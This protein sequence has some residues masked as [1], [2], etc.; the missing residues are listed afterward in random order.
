MQSLNIPTARVKQLNG[1]DDDVLV[2][3]YESAAAFFYSSLYE[4]FGAPV[5]EAM[6]LGF[7]VACANTGSIPEVAGEAAESFNPSDS[8]DICAAIT[9]IVA[10][11][12]HRS[13]LMR[14]GPIR[15]EQ[16]SWSKCAEDTLK[17]HQRALG[18]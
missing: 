13:E 7:P 4:G 11:P 8:A 14:K 12:E 3:L 10:N 18:N 16:F 9:R 15:S 1:N 2:A 17:I 6:S 5:L